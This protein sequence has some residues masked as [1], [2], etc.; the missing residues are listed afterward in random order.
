MNNVDVNTAGNVENKPPQV[1]PKVFD[2]NTAR[3][4]I[5]PPSSDLTVRCFQFI[6]KIFKCV[7]WGSRIITRYVGIIATAIYKI[8][9]KES[10]GGNLSITKTEIAHE[11]IAPIKLKM[12]FSLRVNNMKDAR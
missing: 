6:G 5:V 10:A 9:T 2:K 1:L 12:E 4:I 11:I 8:E 3:A 7:T